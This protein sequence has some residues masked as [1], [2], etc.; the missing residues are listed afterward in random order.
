MIEAGMPLAAAAERNSACNL[1]IAGDP[2]RARHRLRL[3]H[4]GERLRFDHPIRA[5]IQQLV[6]NIVAEMPMPDTR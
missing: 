3:A 4:D 5:H 2:F 1:A 6:G